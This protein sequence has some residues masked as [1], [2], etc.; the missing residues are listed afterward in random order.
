MQQQQ[1]QQPKTSK[2]R[3]SKRARAAYANRLSGEALL[4]NPV[5]SGPPNWNSNNGGF[6]RNWMNT[7]NQGNFNMQ[8]SAQQNQDSTFRMNMP[9]PG[10]GKQP[11]PLMNDMNNEPQFKFQLTEL[12][13][14]IPND[15]QPQKNMQGF[16]VS[17]PFFCNV[18]NLTFSPHSELLKH[19]KGGA[20]KFKLRLLK[21]LTTPKLK[22]PVQVKV[23]PEPPKPVVK[24]VSTYCDLCK[25]NFVGNVIEHRRSEEHKANKEFAR[26]F[27]ALCKQFLRTPARFVKHCKSE[28][29]QLQRSRMAA[30]KA[31]AEKKKPGKQSEKGNDNADKPKEKTEGKKEQGGKLVEGKEQRDEFFTV[32]AVGIYEGSGDHQVITLDDTSDDDERSSGEKLAK[33]KSESVIKSTSAVEDEKSIPDEPVEDQAVGEAFITAG[34]YCYLCSDFF[35]DEKFAKTEHCRAK[36][37]VAN[38]K[39]TLSKPSAEDKIQQIE[40][41]S[42]DNEQS[43]EENVLNTGEKKTEEKKTEEMEVELAHT[44]KQVNTEEGASQDEKQSNKDEEPTSETAEGEAEPSSTSNQ[45]NEKSCDDNETKDGNAK[46]ASADSAETENGHMIIPNPLQDDDDNDDSCEVC[47]ENICAVTIKQEVDS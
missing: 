7:G 46:Q 43:T 24:S 30:A 33:K 19:F 12:T 29:H 13:R 37:H 11:M 34:F 38:Y 8:R 20:H 1:Q 18:C 32:D 16:T 17:G 27:C 40:S 9:G 2:K 44:P 35:E 42:S 36:E 5:S 41:S 10:F 6:Q 21:S 31:E 25:K 4:P 22:K 15:M 28:Y 26:P 23:A 3:P 45:E 14:T 47:F 39:S